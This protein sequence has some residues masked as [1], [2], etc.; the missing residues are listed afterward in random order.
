MNSNDQEWHNW[1]R[2]LHRLGAHQW[3]ASIL[4]VL[5]PLALFGAQL[6]YFGE[7]LLAPLVR[8]DRLEA[9]ASMLENPDSVHSFI[10]ILREANEK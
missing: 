10:K 6:V 5:G 9:L 4:E 8:Q 2:I 3:V 7:P 1:A